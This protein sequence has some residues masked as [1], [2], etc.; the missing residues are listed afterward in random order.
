MFDID[1]PHVVMQDHTPVSL[2]YSSEGTEFLN[3][4]NFTMETKRNALESQMSTLKDRMDDIEE[5]QTRSL[6]SKTR[7][8]GVCLRF[9]LCL[10][11]FFAASH[12][13]QASMSL[14][15]NPPGR[16]CGEVL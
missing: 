8:V 12:D 16:C 5:R 6:Q 10:C 2:R 9:K 7:N 11:L 3:D 14:A 4:N 15:L 13:H 1:T